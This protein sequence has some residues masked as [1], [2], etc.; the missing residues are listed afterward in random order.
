MQI[1][2]SRKLPADENLWLKSLSDQLNS[3]EIMRISEEITRQEKDARIAAYLNVIVEA[4]SK[5]IQEAL[6]MRRK[7]T[8]EQVIEDSG[9][10]AKWE[11]KSRVSI[12]QNMVKMGL[13]FETV[14][15]AT[16]LEPEKVRALYQSALA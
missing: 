16:Q 12:A 7:L 4:N 1:I 6:K 5:S 15:C 14:V 11:A 3:A 13:P 10:G 8:I 9:L 2:D